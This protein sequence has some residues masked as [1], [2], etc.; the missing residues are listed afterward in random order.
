MTDVTESQPST[1]ERGM[2]TAKEAVYAASEHVENVGQHLKEKIEAAQHPETYVQMLMDVTK[3]APYDLAIASRGRPQ[4]R[5]DEIRRFLGVLP[6]LVTLRALRSEL[7]PLVT[8]PT[9][10]ET[11]LNE[12][13]E[14]ANRQLKLAT[15]VQ[16]SSIETSELQGFPNRDSAIR[17]E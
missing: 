1:A 12:L 6:R 8:L 5:I 16:T 13:P 15:Q 17:Q 14:L 4:A 2:E 11:W 9:A 10:P 7:E 3:A